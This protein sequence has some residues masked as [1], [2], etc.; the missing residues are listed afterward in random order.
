[1]TSCT[2]NPLLNTKMLNHVSSTVSLTIRKKSSFSSCWPAG[3]VTKH[4]R[5][6]AFHSP[7]TPLILCLSAAS[8]SSAPPFTFAPN[9]KSFI[10]KIT[11]SLQSV[12]RTVVESAE[13]GDGVVDSESLKKSGDEGRGE[14]AFRRSASLPGEGPSGKREQKEVW[15]LISPPAW[16]LRRICGGEG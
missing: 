9:D 12:S 2:D 5:R 3:G 8:T 6:P 4:F 1:M 15:G 14:M 11:G 13:G 16:S 7:N 10:F